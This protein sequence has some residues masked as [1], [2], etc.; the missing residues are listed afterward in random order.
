MQ[1][2]QRFY[3]VEFVPR[4]LPDAERAAARTAVRKIYIQSAS[5]RIHDSHIFFHTDNS[6][7]MSEKVKRWDFPLVSG[8]T[9]FLEG[10]ETSPFEAVFLL[11]PNHPPLPA[12]LRAP[13]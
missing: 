11:P 13:P 8:G 9:D 7:T 1:K 12:R 10:G 5:H 3:M 6:I 2:P 4:A